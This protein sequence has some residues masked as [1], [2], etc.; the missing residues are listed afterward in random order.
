[1]NYK[2]ETSIVMD[3]DLPAHRML[4][5]LLGYVLLKDSTGPED[6]EIKVDRPRIRFLRAFMWSGGYLLISVLAGYYC[7]F[8]GAPIPRFAARLSVVGVVLGISVFINRKKILVWLVRLYQFRA[9]SHIR[10]RCVMAPSCSDYMILAVTKYGSFR[11]VRMS[12]AR[13]R[14][15]CPPGRIDYP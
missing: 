10:A 11:G 8:V 12:M 13:L 1:M 5:M 15:C 4:I 9:P 3:S 6:L 14:K 2:T 7:H